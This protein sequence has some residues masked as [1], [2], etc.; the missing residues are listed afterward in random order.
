MDKSDDIATGL[1]DGGS[2]IDFRHGLNTLLYSIRSR[3]TCG[4]HP[5]SCAVGTGSVYPGA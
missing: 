5:A 1:D 4:A 2:G 3:P